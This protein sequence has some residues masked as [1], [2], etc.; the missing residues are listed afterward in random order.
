[1]NVYYVFYETCIYHITVCDID[2]Y[3]LGL[4]LVTVLLILALYNNSYISTFVSLYIS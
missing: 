1:M 3:L 4:R 2:Q